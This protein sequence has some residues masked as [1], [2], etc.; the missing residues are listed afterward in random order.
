[1]SRT[2]RALKK[3]HSRRADELR[4]TKFTVIVN[5][6]DG[7]C[8]FC[9][10]KMGIDCTREHLH[11]QARGGT[12]TDPPGN[13]KAAHADC[14]LAVGNLPV[15]DKLRLREIAHSEGRLEMFRVAQQMRRAD[16][17]MAFRS[18]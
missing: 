16:A 18:D 15:S 12:N 9:G 4:Q 5:N 8:W 13:L 14:N 11:S 7:K 3:H 6:Q 2:R 10:T 1:M 17:R